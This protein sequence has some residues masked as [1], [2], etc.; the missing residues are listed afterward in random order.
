M[1]KL[2]KIIKNMVPHCCRF[3]IFND[4]Y[5]SIFVAQFLFNYSMKFG[6][7]KTIEKRRNTCDLNFA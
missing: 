3:T 2:Y 1:S 6:K 4:F 5:C 7:L